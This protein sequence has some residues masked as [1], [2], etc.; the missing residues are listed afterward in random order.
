MEGGTQLAARLLL[1][2]RV[3]AEVVVAVDQ[4]QQL[5]RPGVNGMDTMDEGRR[6]GERE[7]GDRDEEARVGAGE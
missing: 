7:M 2:W 4:L 5:V 3:S 6:H 1:S